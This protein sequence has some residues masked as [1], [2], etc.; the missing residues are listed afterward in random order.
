[1]WFQRIANLISHLGWVGWLTAILFFALGL[2]Y[3]YWRWYRSLARLRIARRG[4]HEQISGHNARTADLHERL[5]GLSRSQHQDVLAARAELNEKSAQLSGLEAEYSEFKTHASSKTAQSHSASTGSNDAEQATAAADARVLVLQSELTSVRDELEAAKTQLNAATSNAGTAQLDSH[6]MGL[7]QQTGDDSTQSTMRSDLEAKSHALDILNVSFDA[8]KIELESSRADLNAARTELTTTKSDLDSARADLA[9]SQGE[10]SKIKSELDSLSTELDSV[11]KEL[12]ESR[13]TLTSVRSELEGT[14]KERDSAR[15]E[16]ETISSAATDHSQQIESLKSDVVTAEEKLTAELK[17]K[18]AL[19]SE[20]QTVRS[21]VESLKQ[22]LTAA[23]SDCQECH[24]KLTAAHHESDKLAAQLLQRD[25]EFEKQKAQLDSAHLSDATHSAADDTFGSGLA[26]AAADTA[27]TAGASASVAGFMDTQSASGIAENA[28]AGLP[29]GETT[30][31]TSAGKGS[32]GNGSGREQ[33][34]DN[35]VHSSSENTGAGN[36]SASRATNSSTDASTQKPNAAAIA[37]DRSNNLEK[38][39]TKNSSTTPTDATS[40]SAPRTGGDA[41]HDS[42][43]DAGTKNRAAETS[44]A[45]DTAAKQAS[46]KNTATDSRNSGAGDTGSESASSV[47]NVASHF[48]ADTSAAGKAVSGT[49]A[50]GKA[51]SGTATGDSTSTSDTKDGDA[52]PGNESSSGPAANTNDAAQSADKTKVGREDSSNHADAKKGPSSGSS[53][54]SAIAET[55]DSPVPEP[56]LPDN[57]D[58][59]AVLAAFGD[60]ADSIKVDQKLGVIYSE[61]PDSVDDLTRISG[62][63]P[64]LEKKLHE[65]GVYT[66]EQI[67]NWNEYNVWEFNRQ[68]S[69][70]GRIEREEW[71]RQ[72]KGLAAEE[73]GSQSGS[74]QDAVA[75]ATDSMTPGAAK[76]GSKHDSASTDSSNADSANAG[77]KAKTAAEAATLNAGASKSTGEE[78]MSRED[79]AGSDSKH[80]QS[81]N[82]N[83]SADS[84]KHSTTGHDR[85]S[86]SADSTLKAVAGLMDSGV[87][88]AR[89]NSGAN[90]KPKRSTA[91]LGDSREIAPELIG[92]TPDTAGQSETESASNQ[93]GSSGAGQTDPGEKTEDQDSDAAGDSNAN[94]ANSSAST[95]K[96]ADAESDTPADKKSESADESDKSNTKTDAATDATVSGSDADAQNESAEQ[97]NLKTPKTPAPA[98]PTADDYKSALAEFDNSA[99]DVNRE[100]GIVFH[101][102]PA[103]TDELTL[104][105]GVG[106]VTEKKLHKSGVYQFKQIANWNEY[107][108]WEFNRQLSF[109]GRIER[110]DWVGQARGLSSATVD[111]SVVQKF[112]GQDVAA[113]PQYGVVFRNKPADADDLTEIAGISKRLERQLNAAGVYKFA[114]I[115]EWNSAN[116]A[117]YNE[118][119]GLSGNIVNEDWPGQAAEFIELQAAEASAP[120]VAAPKR[121]AVSKYKK[122]L[123]KFADE[124]VEV[125]P[126]R[127]IVYKETPDGIDDLTRIKG[128]GRVNEG[129]LHET[130]VY[131]YQQ[132]AEWNK[133]NTW[134]FNQHLSF[135]GR[136][137]RE[138]WVGQAKLL[139]PYSEFTG[140][141]HGFFARSGED[142][143]GLDRIVFVMDVSRSLSD[144]Q[145]RV[146]KVELKKAIRRL[147]SGCHYQII[148]FSGAAW[149]AHERMVDGGSRGKDVVIQ[150][151]SG[152]HHW[153]SGSPFTYSEGNDSLP[154]ADWLQADEESITQSLRDIDAVDK[155]FGTTWHL[156]LTMALNMNPAPQAVYF[157]TDGE[158]ANQDQVA[159]DMISLAESM[160]SPQIHTTSLMEPGAAPPLNKLAAATGGNFSLVHSNGSVLHGDELVEFLAEKKITL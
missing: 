47:T 104:I 5:L 28:D 93:S 99:V 62:I 140:E 115:A 87:T 134:A 51:V 78:S 37:G 72:A 121:P 12:S 86:E 146:S 120:D 109:S 110:E 50:A 114:Q 1:M 97:E 108:I 53:K 69:F 138:D 49:S 144:A 98:M 129:K 136:I 156:P 106:P 127:G 54:S 80:K 76:T 117:V 100:L 39:G 116:Q 130:G 84:K 123:K 112:A 139:A 148:F 6:Q 142:L 66:F 92:K 36:S 57:A 10:L 26:R 38:S 158:T 157:M 24:K 34:T 149:F 25:A 90:T 133:Y 17:A 94:A 70:P 40:A 73:K 103:D 74:G 128:I 9:K 52:D 3:A 82:T 107:N 152:M 124:P 14:V 160:G 150:S 46:D 151:S 132:I 7:L 143:S 113:N 105:R 68:L 42:G 11:R 79:D 56:E 145:L 45:T 65:H 55:S 89:A 41:G 111:D 13:S 122:V 64:V 102:A 30:S 33:D 155:S 27:S 83:D 29:A 71:I 137:E 77:D 95:E 2:W 20:L 4:L 131:R 125:H 23:K 22:E 59:D 60:D 35:R 96:T 153:A 48:V 19:Q 75:E 88:S 119:L 63:G 58:Y 32:Q 126:E 81:S 91:D 154:T 67:A 44:A 141:E 147:G 31:G 85:P 61:R 159:D 101:N 15:S 135:K 8:A 16:V 18:E 43:N 118:K 21:T